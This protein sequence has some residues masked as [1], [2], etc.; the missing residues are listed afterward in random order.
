VY[1]TLVSAM[2]LIGLSA[3]DAFLEK[4]RRTVNL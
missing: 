2:A 4:Y 1:G 3:D